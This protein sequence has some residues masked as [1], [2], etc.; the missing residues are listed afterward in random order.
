MYRKDIFYSGSVTNLKSSQTN[1]SSYAA[2]MLSIP[3]LPDEDDNSCCAAFAPVKAI[4]GEMFDFKLFRSITFVL[5]CTCSILAMTG[6][7]TP[8]VYMTDV[9]VRRGVSPS[10]A[11]FLIA[12][13]G[14]FNTIGRV[15]AGW[16]SDQSWA[17]CLLIHNVAL[18]AAGVST[19]L[20]PFMTQ[21]WMLMVFCAVFGT[22]IA[23]FISL[24]SIVLVELL[25]IENL[26]N[27]FGLLLLFQGIASLM[28]S[29]I[30]GMIF[31]YT[32]SYTASFMTSGAL[33]AIAGIMVLPIR[34]VAAWERRREERTMQREQAAAAE[35][36]ARMKAIDDS[37]NEEPEEDT[38]MM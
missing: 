12:F 23:C 3:D 29:P 37:E 19:C 21:Y 25:G 22:G 24:R 13:L 20:V 35:F 4:L 30:A 16:V 6:F 34:Y 7:F 28:G 38:S 1:M 36:E 14:I 17:D 27:S 26:T 10:S 33:I 15:V 31:D 9:A 11:A 8:F 32:Q 5:M 18:V 2:S